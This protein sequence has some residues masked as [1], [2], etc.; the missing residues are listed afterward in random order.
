M[1]I[2]FKFCILIFFSYFVLFKYLEEC[3]DYILKIEIMFFEKMVL[4]VWYGFFVN[5]S[6]CRGDNKVVD[7]QKENEVLVLKELICGLGFNKIEN[8]VVVIIKVVLVIQDVV[9]NFDKMFNICDKNI[10]YKKCL[11][12][13]DVNC[14]FKE[15]IF[16]KI[17]EKIN[18]RKLENFYKIKVFF[19]I[20]DI[21]YFKDVVMK[22]VERLRRGIVIFLFDSDDEFIL[23]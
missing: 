5:L 6:G 7:L 19:F 16:V 15:F 21:I 4:K 8:V 10:Y 2:F 23:E 12:Q 1:N 3:I 13:D 14:I 18:G 11:F 9:N 22:K 17:W 20:V